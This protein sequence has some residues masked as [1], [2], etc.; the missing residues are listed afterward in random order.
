MKNFIIL[1]SAAALFG[2]SKGPNEVSMGP[3][4]VLTEF[5]EA[6]SSGDSKKIKKAMELVFMSDEEK[7]EFI[8]NLE[9]DSSILKSIK[10]ISTK[11]TVEKCTPPAE[12][13]NSDAISAVSQCSVINKNGEKE[14]VDLWKDKK[15]GNWL[16]FLS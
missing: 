6:M 13:K 8:K 12:I 9:S 10:D 5:N 4:E 11:L 3:K 16:V 7:R 14:A 2:C 1:L 15:T